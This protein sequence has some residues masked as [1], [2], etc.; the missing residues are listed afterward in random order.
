MAALQK[1]LQADDLIAVLGGLQEIELLGGL[2]HLTSG[3]GDEFLHLRTSHVLN[4][5]VGGGHTACGAAFCR[6][7]DAS[8]QFLRVGTVLLLQTA[9]AQVLCRV[10]APERTLHGSQL[11]LHARLSAQPARLPR[12]TGM[13]LL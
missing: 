1:R 5:R 7:T 3:L 4:Y 12:R 11:L 8:H 9:Q 6:H 10:P 13:A 2:F